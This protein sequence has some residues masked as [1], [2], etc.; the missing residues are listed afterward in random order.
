MR[1]RSERKKWRSRFLW[2]DKAPSWED[3]LSRF[4]R[5]YDRLRGSAMTSVLQGAGPLRRR[6]ARIVSG[7]IALVG[8]ASGYVDAI[9]GDGVA[10]AFE[11]AHSLASSLA[12]GDLDPYV[13]AHRRAARRYR[14]MAETVLLLSSY[15]RLRARVLAALA[16]NPDLFERLVSISADGAPWASLGLGNVLRLAASAGSAVIE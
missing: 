16:A 5:L 4:P 2:R 12:S 15:P 9:T 13:E 1:R 10:L 7:R 3:M 8:D 11:C 14:V 6:V